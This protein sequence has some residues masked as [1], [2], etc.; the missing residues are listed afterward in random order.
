VAVPLGDPSERIATDPDSMFGSEQIC[1]RV[2]R[3]ILL[4]VGLALALTGLPLPKS[5]KVKS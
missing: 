2:A 1:P 5:I 3:K 4:S